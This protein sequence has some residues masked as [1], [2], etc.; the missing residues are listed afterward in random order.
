MTDYNVSEAVGQEIIF[1][2]KRNIRD[3]GGYKTL[4][5]RRVNYNLLYRGTD[6]FN[7]SSQDK[8]K[9]DSLNLKQILDLR[10]ASEAIKSPDYIPNNCNYKRCCASVVDGIEIDFSPEA[11]RQNIFKGLR[12]LI[13]LLRAATNYTGYNSIIF[14]N[15][16]FYVMFQLLIK[17]QAPLYFHCS[18]GKDRTGMA[19]ILLLIALGVDIEDALND[20][21]LTNVYYAD[22]IK[23]VSDKHPLLY[24]VSKRLRII[25]HSSEGVS[26]KT[27]ENA[28]QAILS[29]YGTFENYFLKEFDL[30]EQRLNNLRDMYTT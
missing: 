3:L 13:Q 10:S 19:A 21:D 8:K 7:L 11:F 1:E 17:E 28:L 23:K 24:K 9:I 27:A 25:I 26:R 20:F 12:R 2:S 29:R 15:Q 16:A 22:N 4:D 30:D 6:L 5:G 14:D 18:A